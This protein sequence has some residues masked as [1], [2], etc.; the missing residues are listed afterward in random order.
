MAGPIKVMIVD[1]SAIA[2]KMVERTLGSLEGC[3]VHHAQNGLEAV[4][5]VARSLTIKDEPP[6]DVVLMDY[7]MPVMSGPEAVNLIRGQGYLGVILAV[8]GV[9]SESE[10][11]ALLG[12]G[13]D[14]ILVKPFSMEAFKLAMCV[15]VDGW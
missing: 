2:R 9:T 1:D 15:T 4:Q 5:L 13:V 8:T 11:T 12:R 3:V 10:F 14:R 7:Y 6:Y